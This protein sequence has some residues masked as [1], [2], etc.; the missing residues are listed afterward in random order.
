MLTT[1]GGKQT[2]TVGNRRT[3]I[4][5]LHCRQMGGASNC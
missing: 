5:P 2:V 3:S 1:T 4:Y